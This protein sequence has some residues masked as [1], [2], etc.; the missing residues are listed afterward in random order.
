MKLPA[1]LFHLLDRFGKDLAE[2]IE[3]VGLQPTHDSD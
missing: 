2:T 3:V 1:A